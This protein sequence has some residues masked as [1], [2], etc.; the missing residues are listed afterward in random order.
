MPW[1]ILS[2]FIDDMA[3]VLEFSKF[4]MYSDNL[5]IYHSRPRHMLSEWFRANLLIFNPA[6]P[7]LLIH[8]NIYVV[9]SRHFLLVT[10]SSCI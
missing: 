9:L 4:H 6:K 8:S 7:M 2:L 10:I 3:D 1:I 5:Q